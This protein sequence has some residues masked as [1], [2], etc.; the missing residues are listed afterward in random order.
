M[1]RNQRLFT[2]IC[3]SLLTPF[4]F[5]FA[6]KEDCRL[7]KEDLKPIIKRYNPFFSNHTWNLES[8]IEMARMGN[9]RLLLITQDGCLR[10]HITF[11]LII[12]PGKVKQDRSF[13][14]NEV[15]SMMHRVYWEQSEYEQYQKEFEE[16]F[17][18]KFSYYGL[19]DQFNFPIGS[20]NFI[21]EL[22]FD[23]VKGGKITIEVINFIFREKIDNSQRRR[24]TNDSDDGWL[25]T[26]R[27]P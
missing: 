13:W 21:C 26:E 10:H 18:D 15:K 3:L 22:R 9:N 24:I 8:Q 7:K 1:K 5:V 16:N 19:N 12:D 17:E 11:N 4:S 27:R 14:I 25:G 23:P 2:W 20:R 6:Q